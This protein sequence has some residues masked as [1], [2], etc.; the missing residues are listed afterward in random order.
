M[1][2]DHAEDFALC[3]AA[4][5]SAE[6]SESDR[7]IAPSDPDSSLKSGR[8]G[9]IGLIGSR[10]KWGRFRRMLVEAGHDV[11]TV[12]RIQCP[13]GLPSLTSKEP[14]VIAI[15]V[16][17]ALLTELSVMSPEPFDKPRRAPVAGASTS[18]A[19]IEGASTSSARIEGASTSSARIEGASAS[20]A[21]IGGASTSSTRMSESTP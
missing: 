1:T 3:D 10:T 13:I 18:S 19:R 4:L 14:A 6:S 8:W 9:S 11:P 2:H 16:A 7:P 15:G 20:S 17:T 5:S 12:E 21:P